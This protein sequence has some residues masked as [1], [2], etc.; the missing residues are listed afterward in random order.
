MIEF[1]SKTSEPLPFSEMKRISE[2][3]L[4][5]GDWKKALMLAIPA[6]LMLRYSDYT[7]LRWGDFK[8]DRIIIIEKKTEKTKRKRTP[9]TIKVSTEVKRI[10]NEARPEWAD[11][12][13][14]IFA[15][16]GEIK[17][18]TIGYVNNEIKRLGI[19]FN[20]PIEHFSSHSLI[21][22][23]CLELYEKNGKSDAALLLIC[24]I[25][26]HSSPAITMQYLGITQRVIDEAYE[27]L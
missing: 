26:N 17:P 4:K 22:S 9:R 18:F 14:L 15:K 16:K 8:K 13:D 25:R 20:V 11:D 6:Y 5:R 19:E 12:K 10:I 21:K 1:K 23:G 3:L 7:R 27:S 24:K 2:A